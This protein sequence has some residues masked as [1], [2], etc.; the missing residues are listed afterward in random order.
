MAYFRAELI[1][2]AWD[3]V[4]KLYDCVDSN[5]SLMTHSTQI[6]LCLKDLDKKFRHVN[7]IQAYEFFVKY[8]RKVSWLTTY[9]NNR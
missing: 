6:E 5:D 1:A 8:F 3:T 7:N 2:D 4:T 9:T